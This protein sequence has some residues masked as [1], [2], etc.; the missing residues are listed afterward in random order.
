MKF[1]KELIV[2]GIEPSP[3]PYSPGARCGPLIFAAASSTDP[4]TGLAVNGTIEEETERT[5]EN[6]RR[7]LEFAGSGLKDVIKATVYLTN[8]D[9]FEKYNKV[10]AK[11]FKEGGF[12]ARATLGISRLYGNNQ[13]EID[14]IALI[15]KKSRR[16]T[17]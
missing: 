13:I 8:F 15:R 7:I 16:R 5:I 14:V 1:E 4:K 2:G 9:D 10:Y 12:P 6:I 17:N 11:Y 3:I